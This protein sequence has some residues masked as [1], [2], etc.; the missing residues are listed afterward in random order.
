MDYCVPSRRSTLSECIVIIGPQYAPHS[1][2]MGCTSMTHPLPSLLAR[3]VPFA[4]FVC[5]ASLL[6]LLA[7]LGFGL[8][9]DRNPISTRV[10]L[11]CLGLL[12]VLWLALGAFLGSSDAGDSDVECFSSADATEPAEL[13]GCTFICSI[14]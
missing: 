13:P 1:L 5:S 2:F 3:F 7:L 4:I 6:I 14:H 8:W 10:E 11:G 9:K 12:G